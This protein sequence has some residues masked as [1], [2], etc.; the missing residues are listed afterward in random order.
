[1]AYGFGSRPIGD[2]TLKPNTNSNARTQ[3][4]LMTSFDMLKH[5][6]LMINGVDATHYLH[7][8]YLS[9]N[10]DYI[11]AVLSI[12]DDYNDMGTLDIHEALLDTQHYYEDNEY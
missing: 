3:H 7:R 8:A 12:K 4:C 10:K 6:P 2:G 9:N 5:T 11:Q 1:M